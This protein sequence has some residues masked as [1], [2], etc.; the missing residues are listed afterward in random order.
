MSC[1]KLLRDYL[2]KR[3]LRLT[4]QRELVL[5]VLHELEAPATAE[6]IF[7]RVHT[8]SH[9]V[10]IS[11]VYRTLELFQELRLVSGFDAGMA[12]RRTNIWASLPPTIT[13]SA[14]RVESRCRCRW[15]N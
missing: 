5:S 10:D 15:P 3:G 7:A 14:R 6:E 2:R 8:R 9:N 12:F 11:T 4:H 13:W 1:E